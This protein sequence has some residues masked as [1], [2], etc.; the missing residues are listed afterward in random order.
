MKTGLFIGKTPAKS[1]WMRQAIHG[2]YWL[3]SF[4]LLYQLGMTNSASR[5]LA[6]IVPE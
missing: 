6:E 5:Q 3:W 2:E 4:L 1:K